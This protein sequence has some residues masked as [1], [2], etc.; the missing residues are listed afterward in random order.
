MTTADHRRLL[1]LGLL[2]ASELHAH[3]SGAGLFDLKRPV[4]Y[5]PA[6]HPTGSGSLA[7][8]RRRRCR[9]LASLAYLCREQK[10]ASFFPPSP[11]PQRSTRG[12]PTQLVS[13]DALDVLRLLR[14]VSTVELAE[15]MTRILTDERSVEPARHGMGLLRELF[16]RG[17]EGAERAA[18]R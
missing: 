18:G 2:H 13:K 3:L 9:P 1:L 12:A 6:Q 8:G 16:G 4:A 10:F 14:G 5:G 11:R 17:R 7:P 15:R